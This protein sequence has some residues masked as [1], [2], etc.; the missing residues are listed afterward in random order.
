MKFIF[1]FIFIIISSCS[2]SKFKYRDKNTRINKLESLELNR[3]NTVVAQPLCLYRPAYDQPLIETIGPFATVYNQLGKHFPL[4]FDSIVKNLEVENKEL[5]KINIACLKGKINEEIFFKMNIRN[6]EG[7]ISCFK[8]TGKTIIFYVLYFSDASGGSDIYN[9]NGHVYL[10]KNG[11]LLYFR[12]V[13]STVA[14]FHSY[15]DSKIFPTNQIYRVLYML[16][17]EIRQNIN[18]RYCKYEAVIKFGYLAQE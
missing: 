1:V 17:K 12:S 18:P 2:V 11:Q 4:A 8:D 14:N 13:K 6:F 10:I 7:V 15:P 16:S 9:V 3:G 5:V